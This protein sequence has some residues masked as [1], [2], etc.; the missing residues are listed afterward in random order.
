MRELYARDQS[1]ARAWFRRYHAAASTAFPDPDDLVPL[2]EYETYSTHPGPWEIAMLCSGDQLLG[3]CHWAVL[4][5]ASGRHFY[6][7]GL[8]WV[9][10]RFRGRGLAAH[11]IDHVLGAAIAGHPDLLGELSTV[12][13]PRLMTDEQVQQ[14]TMN[15][16]DR[17]EYWAHKGLLAFD[18]PYIEP[19][20]SPGQADVRHY[21]AMMRPLQESFRSISR[22]QYL[23]I[24]RAYFD[25]FD[26]T[27]GTDSRT[28]PAYRE[29]SERTPPEVRLIPFGTPRAHV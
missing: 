15:P 5:T 12:A 25:S 4:E 24:L 10:R 28:L 26:P 16:Q 11:M 7:G 23:E 19:S 22:A 27:G 2:E 3:G 21:M 1:C 17:L 20:L 29:I 8:V 6:A 18:A 9:D 13:D 14:S